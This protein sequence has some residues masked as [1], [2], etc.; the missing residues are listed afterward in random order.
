MADNVTQYDDNLKTYLQR[1]VQ[2]L[3]SLGYIG[4]SEQLQCQL[5]EI[6]RQTFTSTWKKTDALEELV[7]Q[8]VIVPATHS[9]SL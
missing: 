2:A 5:E 8:W 1:E 3:R 6:E 7:M 9:G 4:E